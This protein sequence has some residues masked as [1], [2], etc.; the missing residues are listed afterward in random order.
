MNFSY[1]NNVLFLEI[2]EDYTDVLTLFKYSII[3]TLTGVHFKVFCF[4]E[5]FKITW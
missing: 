4:N 3:C 1:G 2:I 5:Y